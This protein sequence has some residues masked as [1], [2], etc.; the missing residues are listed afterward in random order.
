MLRFQHR[1][2]L[3]IAPAMALVLPTVV[4]GAL[5]GDWWGGYFVAGL[6]RLV[7]VHHSTFFVNSLAHYAGEATYSDA[8][9]SRNSWIT[10]VREQVQS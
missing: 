5:W 7:F 4:C 2:Y 3:V 8:N 1:W 10:A 6:A 9:T